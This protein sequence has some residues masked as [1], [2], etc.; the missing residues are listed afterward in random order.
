MIIVKMWQKSILI[1]FAI[2]AENEER[3]QSSN[4]C[5]ICNKLFGPGD[6]EARD[7]DHVAG[8]YRGSANWSCNSN[9]KLTKKVSVIFHDLKGYDSHLIMQEIGKFDGKISVIPNGLEKY[10]AF[11]I[12]KNLFFID[13]MQFMN[14]ILDALVKNLSDNDFK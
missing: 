8:K 14:S 7:H 1:R 11:T 12:N 3:F 9:I 13:S 6:N 2:S 5:W 4:K 10:M